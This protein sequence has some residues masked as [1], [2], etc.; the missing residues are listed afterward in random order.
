MQSAVV[1]LKKIFESGMPSAEQLCYM[2]Y[3]LQTSTTRRYAD[4]EIT[5]SLQTATVEEIMPLLP[6]IKGD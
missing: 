2:D 1:S 5:A 3:S 4:P 6:H